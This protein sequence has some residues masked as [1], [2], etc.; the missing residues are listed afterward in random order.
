[1]IIIIDVFFLCVTVIIARCDLTFNISKAK[2]NSFVIYI[3]HTASASFR[4]SKI[5]RKHKRES[6]WFMRFILVRLFLQNI[7]GVFVHFLIRLF[8]RLLVSFMSALHPFS[9]QEIIQFL[10]FGVDC[11]VMSPIVHKLQLY[12]FF[13]IDF[14]LI[15][16]LLHALLVW[17]NNC[18][19]FSCCAHQVCRFKF[20]W[21]FCNDQWTFRC[22]L[23]TYQHNFVAT[24]T[25]MNILFWET[26]REVSNI[27]CMLISISIVSNTFFINW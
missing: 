2:K 6:L 12:G 19:S 5:A 21:Y 26:R 13:L 20:Q 24:M 14:F 11:F 22:I 17:H 15:I 1:M 10:P 16:P 4:F 7:L 9:N 3:T 18:L 8:V 23:V 27:I 25:W